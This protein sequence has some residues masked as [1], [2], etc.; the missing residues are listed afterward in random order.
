MLQG[1]K[2][3]F[4]VRLIRKKKYVPKGEALAALSCR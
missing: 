4:E 2:Y 1:E 3:G